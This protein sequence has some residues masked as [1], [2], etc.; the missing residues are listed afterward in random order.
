VHALAVRAAGQARASGWPDAPPR[1]QN[2]LRHVRRVRDQAEL[3]A[4]ER[5]QNLHGALAVRP[6]AAGDL[7]GR[8]VVIMDDVVT[9][10]ATLA[11]AARALTCAGAHVVGACCLCVTTRQQGVFDSPALV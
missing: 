5:R 6:R 3:G 8:R 10:G 7:A 1:V 9:T 4:H 11:E 2:V